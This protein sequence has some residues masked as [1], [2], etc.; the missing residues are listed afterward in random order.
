VCLF[1]TYILET[2]NVQGTAEC[3]LLE[4]KTRKSLGKLWIWL[5]YWVRY[6]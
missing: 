6:P 5:A 1:I 2:D 4:I 3:F